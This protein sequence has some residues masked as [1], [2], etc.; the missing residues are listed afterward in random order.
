MNKV[1]TQDP[2]KVYMINLKRK[3]IGDVINEI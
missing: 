1:W 2:M 3:V